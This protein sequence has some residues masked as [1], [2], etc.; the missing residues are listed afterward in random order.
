MGNLFAIVA[1]YLESTGVR[2]AAFARKIGAA[3]QTV[4][5]WKHRGLRSLP[6]R[7]WLVAIAN[8]TGTPYETVLAA[9]LRDA[10]Y[11]DSEV[12]I[13]LTGSV[14]STRGR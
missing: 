6:R 3:P 10:G 1:D 7:E 4:S 14:K 12:E 5:S 8:R 13:R 9:A 2:E 11:I